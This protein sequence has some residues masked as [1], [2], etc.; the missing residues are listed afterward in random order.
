MTK[1][2]WGQRLRLLREAVDS[3]RKDYSAIYGRKPTQIR[4]HENEVG[5]PQLV[6]LI[7]LKLETRVDL[8]WLATGEGTMFG[9]SPL[10]PRQWAE[11]RVLVRGIVATGE[12]VDRKAD[13]IVNLLHSILDAPPK[14][15]TIPSS[16]NQEP[17]NDD[18]GSPQEG[19]RNNPA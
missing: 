3:S 5:S 14:S 4:E 11:L 12:T 15:D 13:M 10:S 9:E 2:G 1:I 6:N 16:V 8:N 18:A 17:A 7:R 19:R